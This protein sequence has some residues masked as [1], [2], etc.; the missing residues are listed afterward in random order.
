MRRCQRGA[1]HQQRGCGPFFGEPR[2]DEHVVGVLGRDS[3]VA[4]PGAPEEPELSAQIPR[5]LYCTV[6]AYPDAA[7]ALLGT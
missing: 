7:D 2:S 4:R 1:H 6:G 3:C 5:D